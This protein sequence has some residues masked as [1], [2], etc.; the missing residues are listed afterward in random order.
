MISVQLLGEKWRRPLEKRC[1]GMVWE[2][3]GLEN[4]G[5]LESGHRSV[6]L[7]FQRKPSS[8]WVNFPLFLMGP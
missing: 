2:S 4:W 3:H 5:M 8:E 1:R 7:I 6:G